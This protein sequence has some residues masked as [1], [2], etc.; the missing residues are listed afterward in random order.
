MRIVHGAQL[1]A[2]EKQTG[3]A[4]LFG[5]P[6]CSPTVMLRSTICLPNYHGKG[7]AVETRELCVF[8]NRQAL[9]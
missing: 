5:P 8:L 6:C 4:L 3:G 2:H 7:V 1:F 9:T